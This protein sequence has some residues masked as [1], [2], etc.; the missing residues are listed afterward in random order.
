MRL[1]LT[2]ILLFV[3][4]FCGQVVLGRAQSANPTPQPEQAFIQDWSQEVI[5]PS[6]VR[7][8]L[9]L[10]L[11]PD[12][13]KDVTL[14]I[15]PE[16]QSPITIPL[17]LGSTTIVGGPVTGIAYLW[18]IPADNP[19]ILFKDIT[20]D[21]QATSQSGQ[22]AKIEDKFNFVDQ[23]ANW[24]RDLAITNNLKLTLPNGKPSSSTITP[25]YTRTG[26]DNLTTNLK[27][28]ADLLAANLGSI[29]TFNLLVDDTTLLPICTNNAK[30]ESVAVATSSN[31]E[32]ACTPDLADKIFVLSGYT[33]LKLTSSTLGAIQSAVSNYIVEQSYASGW[34]GKNIPE[35]FQAGLTEFYSPDSKADLNAPALIAARSNSLLPL[36]VMAKTPATNTNADLWRSESYGLVVYI[37]SQIGVKGLFKLATDAGTAAS[38]EESYQSATGKP[39]NSLLGSFG[40]WLFTD[41]ASGAFT[42]TAYQAATPSPTPTR[43]ATFTL[44]PTPSSTPTFTPSPTVTGVLSPTPLP[45]HTPT[46]TPPPAPATNTPRPAGSL[47]TPTPTPAQNTTATNVTNTNISVGIIILAVGAIIVL[48]AAYILYRPRR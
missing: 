48:I 26:I 18:Q 6:A 8:T 23:R 3:A 42:F 29:P 2:T 17:D 28:V 16:N 44:T 45:S 39:I 7:F 10:A 13:V 21:W 37:A 47:N 14:T 1:K 22:S 9:T 31:T 15:K 40:R 41:A 24:L 34:S 11:P 43:T 27:Q 32:V 36:D 33:T 25:A 5:F 35:W 46:L 4:L 19:P 12:Q 30:G 38:F 20:F